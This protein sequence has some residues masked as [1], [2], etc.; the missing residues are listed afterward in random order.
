MYVR[1]SLST[2]CK[3]LL[4]A[5]RNCSSASA[6]SFRSPSLML[7]FLSRLLSNTWL[8][9][10]NSFFNCSDFVDLKISSHC[11]LIA[12]RFSLAIFSSFSNLFCN[13]FSWYFKNTSGL[14]T[15]KRNHLVIKIISQI[16]YSFSLIFKW[17]VT[18]Y[19]HVSGCHV[20]LNEVIL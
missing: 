6:I 12:F 16:I 3:W 7:S 8:R 14:V 11:V 10:D 18:D 2:L 20:Y 17:Y 9:I 15:K 1:I 5:I 4:F 19:H 13:Y